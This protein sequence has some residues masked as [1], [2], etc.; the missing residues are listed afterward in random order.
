MNTD[1]CSFCPP[2]LLSST[3]K[4]T[5]ASLVLHSQCMDIFLCYLLVFGASFNFPFLLLCRSSLQQCCLL[6]RPLRDKVVE[7]NE[8][9][10][11]L[12]NLWCLPIHSNWRPGCAGGDPFCFL[13]LKRKTF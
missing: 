11:E 2:L 8:I 10:V 6:L 5:Q 7:S 9:A 3:K 12:S 1:T 13:W 4:V